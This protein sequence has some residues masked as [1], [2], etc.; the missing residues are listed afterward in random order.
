[1]LSQTLSA[2]GREG[3][4]KQVTFVLERGDTSNK[5]SIAVGATTVN[6]ILLDPV[7]YFDPSSD[8][9]EILGLR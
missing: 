4:W 9:Y 1:M 3:L 2:G 8:L 5:Y 6:G 7:G